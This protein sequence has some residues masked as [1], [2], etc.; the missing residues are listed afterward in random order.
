MECSNYT[1]NCLV[2]ST[3]PRISIDIFSTWSFLEVYQN[4]YKHKLAKDTCF[5][6]NICDDYTTPY[7]TDCVDQFQQGHAYLFSPLSILEKNCFTLQCIPKRCISAVPT[8]DSIKFCGSASTLGT[9]RCL[10]RVQ[11]DYVVFRA[12]TDSRLYYVPTCSN[13]FPWLFC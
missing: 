12:H 5:F 6:D 7:T 3:F 11:Y 10:S 9:E 4:Q 8:F 2:L 1:D 13:L